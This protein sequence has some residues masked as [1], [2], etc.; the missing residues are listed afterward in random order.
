MCAI[1]ADSLFLNI[2]IQTD[3]ETESRNTLKGVLSKIS[4]IYKYYFIYNRVKRED[5]IRG[6][7]HRHS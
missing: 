4:V 3:V 5:E 1:I 2:F 6:F 7:L